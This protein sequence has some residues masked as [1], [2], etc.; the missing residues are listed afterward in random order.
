[1]S[2]DAGYAT[3]P[4][5]LGNTRSTVSLGGAGSTAQDLRHQRGDRARHSVLAL[6]DGSD[7]RQRL[8]QRR[9]AQLFSLTLSNTIRYLNLPVVGFL[10]TDTVTAVAL[11]AKF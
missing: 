5:L 2:S 1:M 8:D 7:W 9:A 6:S 4:L 10:N 11:V 3:E